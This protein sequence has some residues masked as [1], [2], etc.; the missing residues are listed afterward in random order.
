MPDATFG[1][2]GVAALDFGIAGG[3]GGHAVAFEPDG[4][5]V[6]TGEVGPAGGEH[7]VVARLWP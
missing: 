1:D 4:R 6:L 2:G 7:M 5:I 3:T